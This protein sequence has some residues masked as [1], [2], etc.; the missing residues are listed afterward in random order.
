[1]DSLT[2]N[3]I[4][5]APDDPASEIN[6][7]QWNAGHVFREVLVDPAPIAGVG[8]PYLF[9]DGGVS[10]NKMLEL[11]VMLENGSYIGLGSQLV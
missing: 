5:T 1:M 10:P 2:H 6:K 3:A 11:R 9:S 8:I 7:D 4:A